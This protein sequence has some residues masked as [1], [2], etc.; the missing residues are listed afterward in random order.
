MHVVIADADAL[1]VVEADTVM[2]EQEFEHVVALVAG[3]RHWPEDTHAFD[4][5]AESVEHT[6]GDRRLAGVALH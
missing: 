3:P 6:E 5:V 4:L 2:P 1:V